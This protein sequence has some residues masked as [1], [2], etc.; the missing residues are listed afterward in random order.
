MKY[1]QLRSGGLR[2]HCTAFLPAD[3]FLDDLSS[4]VSILPK[5]AANPLPEPDFYEELM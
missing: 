5:F 1:A 4:A 3:V 2:R